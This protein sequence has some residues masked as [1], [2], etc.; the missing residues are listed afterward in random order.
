MNRLAIHSRY[1]HV[2][3]SAEELVLKES[4]FG[5]GAV[6]PVNAFTIGFNYDLWHIAKARIA[7]GSQFTIYRADPKLNSLYG[8][9]PM[10]FEIYLR[11]YPSLMK[12]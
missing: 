9:N 12:M 1:E 6:F 7:A 8:K 4:D 10:A 3:K 11:V 5:Q 2:Q